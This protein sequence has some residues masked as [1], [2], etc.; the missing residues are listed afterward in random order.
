MIWGNIW[1]TYFWHYLIGSKRSGSSFRMFKHINHFQIE[2]FK[3]KHIK[4]FQIEKFK[5]VITSNIRP[6]K[7]LSYQV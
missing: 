7:A 6:D 3:F 5:E 4:Q 2:K 1:S